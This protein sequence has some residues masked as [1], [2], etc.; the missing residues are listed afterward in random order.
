[1]RQ[2]TDTGIVK[3]IGTQFLRENAYL[4]QLSKRPVMPTP[5]DGTTLRFKF[6]LEHRVLAYT[7]R[8]NLS[9]NTCNIGGLPEHVPMTNRKYVVDEVM[10]VVDIF[11]GFTGLDRTRNTE[12]TPDSHLFR[13]EDG[14]IK[15]IHTASAC[16][17]DGCGMNG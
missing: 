15:Y 4:V 6:P 2:A 12:G 5:I 8:G 17:V 14:K 10:G 11:L 7:R 3:K 13:V 16:F 1:M 9:A